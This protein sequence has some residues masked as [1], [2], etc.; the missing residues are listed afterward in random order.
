MGFEKSG[1]WP[2][3]S[4]VVVN[5]VKSI[6][7]DVPPPNG[8][9][10]NLD[11]EYERGFS[12]EDGAIDVNQKLN[13]LYAKRDENKRYAETFAEW[14]IRAATNNQLNYQN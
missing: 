10:L 6:S 8:N 4:S 1:I 2:L 13:I 9:L 14:R 5:Q 7:L 3:S 12:D 11:E